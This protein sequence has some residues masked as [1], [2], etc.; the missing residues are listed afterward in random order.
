MTQWL[1][2]SESN[3]FFALAVY[4]MSLVASPRSMQT[5]SM[6]LFRFLDGAGSLINIAA[7][8]TS[9]GNHVEIYLGTGIV[10]IVIGIVLLVILENKIGVGLTTF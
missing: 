5:T 2:L 10:T 4:E 8:Y 6:G 3:K 1:F 9:Y 7:V